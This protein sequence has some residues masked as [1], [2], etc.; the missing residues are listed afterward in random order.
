MRLW[1]IVS[2]LCAGLA[3]GLIQLGSGVRDLPVSTMVSAPL[4]LGAA[5]LAVGCLELLVVAAAVTIARTLSK[6]LSPPA[7]LAVA[8]AAILS[9]LYV[10]LAQA[11][12]AGRYARTLSLRWLW[13]TLVVAAMAAF[14]IYALRWLQGPGR[15]WNVPV[16]RG[17]STSVWLSVA[18]LTLLG[19]AFLAAERFLFVRRYLFLHDC[20]TAAGFLSLQSAVG[21]LLLSRGRRTRGWVTPSLVLLG[22]A[23][24]AVVFR[25]TAPEYALLRQALASGGQFNLRMLDLS[26]RVPTPFR[27]APSSGRTPAPMPV[28]SG[29]ASATEVLHAG[30]D[31]V[32]VTVDALRADHLG[33]HGYTR[34]TSPVLDELAG[35]AVVFER[36]YAPTPHTSFS[37]VSLLTGR[38]VLPLA[39]AGRL[40]GQP[41][42]ADGFRAAGYRTIGI[43]PP[44]VFFVERERFVAL[45]RRRLGFEE[46]HFQSLD[47]SRDAAGR[48]DEAIRLLEQNRTRPVFLWVHYFG[49]HEPYVEHPQTGAASFGPRDVDRYDGEIRSVDR[50]LGRLLA[51]LGRSR[52]GAIVA[53]TADHGEE[54]AEHG[55]AYHGTSLFDEQVRVPLLL[56]IPSVSPRRISTAVSTTDVLPTLL[57]LT[58]VAWSAPTDGSSLAGLA[59]SARPVARTVF[60]ELDGLRMAATDRYKLLCDMSRDVCQLFDLKTDPSERRNQAAR[61]PLVQQSLFGD[62]LAWVQR[63][64]P[65]L[66]DPSTPDRA[67]A[68]VIERAFR[69]E[70]GAIATLPRLLRRSS[71]PEAVPVQHRRHAA[72]LLAMQPSP[73]DVDSLALVAATDPDLSVRSWAMVAAVLG[74]QADGAAR[75]AALDTP[76]DDP[77]LGAYRALALTVAGHG[78]GPSQAALAL[79]LTT[80]SQTRCR[81]IKAL[82]ASGDAVA[83]SALRTAYADVRVRICVARAL[84][85]LRSPE[86]TRFAIERLR[87]EPYTTVRAALVRVLGRAA[88]REGTA[89]LQ[90]LLRHEIEPLVRASVAQALVDLRRRARAGRS[91]R[92]ARADQEGMRFADGRTASMS[93]AKLTTRAHPMTLNQ[94]NPRSLRAKQAITAPSDSSAPRKTEPPRIFLV[95]SASKK[96]PRIVP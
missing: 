36:A 58:G 39:R 9:P 47:E 27:Q 26:L 34:A 54:F 46:V 79:E 40:Q 38:H 10:L 67:F 3:L 57:E 66:K 84:V 70:T 51:Y 88:N 6:T 20:L 69:G 50:E 92:R 44:A 7:A 96:M 16:G 52:P 90:I 45:E 91:R 78:E 56:A 60:A 43:F 24:L 13:M 62:L 77:E 65:E 29:S 33:F 17:R 18:V 75:V 12:F 42:A 49:P 94:R 11:A 23:G 72:Q 19:V 21:L 35:R 14:T 55:G 1:I 22:A 8:A 30:A 83:L 53:L 64:I 89:A 63:D 76:A 85:E 61:L 41:T 82:G 5:G 87:D 15:W 71:S 4:L 73:P 31:V 28:L 48:T 86:V 93:A 37:L 2:A 32:L 68:S 80:N 81:L 59:W 95:K 25:I 74:G